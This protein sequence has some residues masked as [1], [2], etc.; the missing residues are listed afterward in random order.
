MSDHVRLLVEYPPK[1]AVSALVNSLKGVSSRLLR[2]ERPDIQRRYWKGV[3]L[4]TLLLR[5]LLR[6]R[7]DFYRAP[8][9]RTA[10]DAHL[11]GNR[12]DPPSGAIHP[13]PERRGFSRKT[14]NTS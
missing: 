9:H 11:N 3:L 7:T 8:V 14:V 2:Q 10:T 12:T 4:V 6:G 1:V 13:R 5:R